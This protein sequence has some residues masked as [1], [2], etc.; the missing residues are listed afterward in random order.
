MN[1]SKITQS[2]TG[3]SALFACD[4]YQAN[5]NVGIGAAVTSGTPTFNI[6]YTFDDPLVATPVTW[7]VA[8]GFSAISATTGGSFTVPCKA[9]SINITGGSGTVTAQFCQAGPI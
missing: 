7:F 4:D 1:V 8:S 9:L 5:F 6:E 2:T 3:R